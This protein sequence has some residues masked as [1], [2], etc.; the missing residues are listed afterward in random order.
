MAKTWPP[1]C[2]VFFY[3]IDTESFEGETM[4]KYGVQTDLEK[5]KTAD[6]SDRQ[7]CPKCGQEL[8]K[9]DG[10]YLSK[11]PSHGT[12]PFEAQK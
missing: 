1:I 11:C 10:V 3:N 7:I 12:E 6:S 5:T 4:E 8:E 2:H 9:V